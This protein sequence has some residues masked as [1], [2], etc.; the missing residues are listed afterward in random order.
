M[1]YRRRSSGGVPSGQLVFVSRLF[2]N[3]SPASARCRGRGVDSE[4]LRVRALFTH[5]PLYHDRKPHC[6]EALY[7]EASST[8]KP[9]LRGNRVGTGAGREGL[10]VS[11]V[12]GY[13]LCSLS[14]IVHA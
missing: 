7:R 5:K 12:F 9:L 6:H 3:L 2:S 10:T 4:R 13:E 1:T 11:S 8:T 14:N